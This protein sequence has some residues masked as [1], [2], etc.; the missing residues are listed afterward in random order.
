MESYHP[1]RCATKNNGISQFKATLLNDECVTKEVKRELFK[2]IE[3][4]GNKYPTYQK[5]Q[6]VKNSPKRGVYYCV[7]EISDKNFNVP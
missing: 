4:N 2:V 5:V 6:A 7:K 1:D 3:L